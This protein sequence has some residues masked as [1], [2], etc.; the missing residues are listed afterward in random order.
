MLAQVYLIEPEVAETKVSPVSR[1]RPSV[2]AK[3]VAVMAEKSGVTDLYDYLSSN[4]APTFSSTFP[5]FWSRGFNYAFDRRKLMLFVV[6]IDGSKSETGLKYRL[7]GF[8]AVNHFQ[9]DEGLLRS[10]LPDESEDLPA[11][12]LY[13]PHREP[14]WFGFKGFFRTRNDIERFLSAFQGKKFGR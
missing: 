8:R 2:T 7:N 12:E 14:D 6:D 11:S 5:R 9:L 4:A 1:I 10:Y 3:E 13:V